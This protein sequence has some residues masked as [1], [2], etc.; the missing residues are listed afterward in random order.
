[1]RLLHI[2]RDMEEALPL[3]VAGEQQA[4]GHQVTVLLLHDAVLRQ[5]S[6]PGRVLACEADMAARGVEGRYP[7]VDYRGIVQAIVDH[8]RVISW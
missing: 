8:D 5:V 6:F 2:V 1:M 4:Q 7:A 3:R